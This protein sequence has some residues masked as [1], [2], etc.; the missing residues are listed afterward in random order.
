MESCPKRAR[1]QPN[2]HY[3][4]VGRALSL[5]SPRARGSFWATP[6]GFSGLLDSKQV[7]KQ[8]FSCYKRFARSRNSTICRACSSCF[9]SISWRQ[10]RNWSLMGGFTGLLDMAISFDGPVGCSRMA[11]ASEIGRSLGS[12]C[13]QALTY[14]L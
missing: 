8:S 7:R 1:H 4:W 9:A 14:R 3:G 12:G 13:T 2:D 11:K 6:W 5:Y 10:R